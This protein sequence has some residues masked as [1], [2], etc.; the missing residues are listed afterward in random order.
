MN[1]LSYTAHHQ[2][3]QIFEGIY[4]GQGL[5]GKVGT[6]KRVQIVFGFLSLSKLG[7]N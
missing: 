7:Y 3:D 6:D 4:Q 5:S 2:F 1:E